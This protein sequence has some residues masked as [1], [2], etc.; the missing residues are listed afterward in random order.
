MKHFYLIVNK[1]KENAQKGA[2]VISAYL[3]GRG[4]E[5]IRRDSGTAGT[6][7]F[8]YTDGRLVPQKT[9]CVIVLGGDGTL[10]QAARD[11]AGRNLPLFGVNMGHLGYL[12]Q[13]SREDEIVPALEELMADHYRLEK[14]MMLS[15]RV[16]TDQ[17][18]AERDLALNDIVLSRTGLYTLKFDLYVNGELFNNYSADGMIVATPTGSTA[19]NL[20]A[21][22]PIAEPESRMIILTPIC[23]HTLNSRSIVISAESKIILEVTGREEVEQF[24]SFDGDTIV[25]LKKGDRI[26]IESSGI[27]TTLIQLKRVSFLENIRCKMKQI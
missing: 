19:Y 9:E 23:P 26:E 25:Q 6:S 8:R 17:G 12:A 3:T 4:C 7:G 20:S 11:L 2:E 27:T 22:G 10:I 15:G 5:C 18:E 1:E 13:I 21:G 16:I 24:L 14:R